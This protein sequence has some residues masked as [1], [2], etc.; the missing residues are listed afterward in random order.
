MKTSLLKWSRVGVC[1]VCLSCMGHLACAYAQQATNEAELGQMG[2][3]LR[4]GDLVFI[5][6]LP[7]PFEKVAQATQSWTNHVGI[8]VGFSGREA[9]VAESTFP[10]SRMTTF[11]RFVARSGKGRVAVLRL[12]RELSAAERRAVFV[13]S[14]RRLG[15]FYDTGFDLYSRRQFCSRF[16]REV[17]AE[18]TQVDVGEVEDFKSLLRRNPNTDLRFWQAW[19]FG[20]IP[21]QRRTVTPAS[22]LRSDKLRV[23]FDGYAV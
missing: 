16:V 15:V 12:P 8:V 17:L 22:L 11:S 10:L 19:Y 14:E 2:M 13:A 4:V 20:F 1:A 9:I 23:V 5:H 21:W 3:R 7:W 18:A 6:S